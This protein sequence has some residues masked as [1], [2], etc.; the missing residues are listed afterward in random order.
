MAE[1]MLTMHLWVNYLKFPTTFN[2]N[3]NNNK[4]ELTNENEELQKAILLS[5]L[6]K[7]VI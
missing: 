1:F 4:S 2:N 3:N 5:S 7:K 6:E